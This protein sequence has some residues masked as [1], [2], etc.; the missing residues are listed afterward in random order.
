MKDHLLDISN[1]YYI[2]DRV[3][4]LG[5][6]VLAEAYFNFGKL[7]LILIPVVI[8][9]VLTFLEIEHLDIGDLA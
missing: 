6:S 9:M 7:G 8:G 1:R 4:G 2:K 5:Y 3:P